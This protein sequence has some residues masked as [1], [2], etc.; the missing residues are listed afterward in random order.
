[1]GI[2]D[3]PPVAATIAGCAMSLFSSIIG[4]LITAHRANV[5]ISVVC[6]TGSLCSSTSFSPWSAQHP[7]FTGE[8]DF[9]E[10]TFPQYIQPPHP[11]KTDEK[12]PP[13]PKFS[14]LNTLIK[15]ILDQSIGAALNTLAFTTFF[16]AIHMAMDPAPRITSPFKAANYWVQAGAIDFGRVDY[17]R[18][19]EESKLQMLP[20]M[21]A[22]WKLWPAVSLVNFTMLTTVE[23]R[24]LVG[25]L[26]GIGWGIYM[27]IVA[28][29]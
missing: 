3:S 16:S 15:F 19:W 29:G 9:L 22:G 17:G 26:A 13:A 6:L 20:I 10:S 27:S 12:T 24:G 1:M 25:G 8:Q 23:A 14:I 7:T 2:A 5:S 11:K 18:V 28:R 21:K 4:Q